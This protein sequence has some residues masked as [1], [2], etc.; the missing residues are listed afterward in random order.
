M[1]NWP[2]P[3]GIQE[4]RERIQELRGCVENLTEERNRA[5]QILSEIHLLVMGRETTIEV[6]IADRLE[7]QGNSSFSFTPPRSVP[8]ALY[9]DRP[10][11]QKGIVPIKAMDE[12]R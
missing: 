11:P 6:E 10:R 12:T 4:A 2:T 1:T 8:L 7:A 9:T 3:Q 5:L